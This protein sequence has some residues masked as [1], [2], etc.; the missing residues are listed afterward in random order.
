MNGAKLMGVMLLLIAGINYYVCINI[1][2]NTGIGL[3]DASIALITFVAGVFTTVIGGKLVG[4][5][6]EK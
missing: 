1:L 2:A 4:I 5:L 3:L 6:I